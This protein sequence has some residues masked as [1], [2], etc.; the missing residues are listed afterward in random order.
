MKAK[1]FT[2]EEA[3]IL[4][5]D[6]EPLMGKL[7]ERRAR[8]IDTRRSCK[9]I[10]FSGNSD[11]GGPLPSKIVFDFIAMDHIM[12]RIRSHGCKIKDVNSGLVDFLSL[13]DGREV[14]LCWK[15]GEPRVEHY[16]ELHSGFM[17]R[18]PI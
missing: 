5:A 18:Q 4:L 12:K 7:L 13:K 1:F 2:V 6:I 9:Q 10:L 3:N 11:F 15:Y 17:G 14:Y 8:V 16:H